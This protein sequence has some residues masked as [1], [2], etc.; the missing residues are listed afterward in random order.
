LSE[1]NDVNAYCEKDYQMNFNKLIQRY[2]CEADDEVDPATLPKLHPERLPKITYV[3][4]GNGN[5]YIFVGPDILKI[6]AYSPSQALH[7][8]RQRYKQFSRERLTAVDHIEYEHY[9]ERRRLQRQRD[10]ER[11]RS[12]TPEPTLS[13]PPPKKPQQTELNFYP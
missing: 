9:Q 10:A 1:K 5:N 4:R 11:F 7:F 8:L 2:L 12:P 13:T 3:F 6:N